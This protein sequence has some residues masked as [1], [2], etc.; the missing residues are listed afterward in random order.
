MASASLAI[1]SF[2]ELGPARPQLVCLFSSFSL[3]IV[4]FVSM[5]LLVPFYASQQ[6]YQATSFYDTLVSLKET[7]RM[8]L[9]PGIKIIPL[10]WK[11]YGTLK[12][13]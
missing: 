7:K 13:M 8:S 1:Q 12:I 4:L 3:S 11:H 10:H 2:T 9:I 6:R 5:C